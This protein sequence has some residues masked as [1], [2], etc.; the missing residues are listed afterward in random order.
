MS[1]KIFTFLPISSKNGRVPKISALTTGITAG[2]NFSKL[3]H[4][5]RKKIIYSPATMPLQKLQICFFFSSEFLLL[6]HS[7]EDYELIHIGSSLKHE[8]DAD[9]ISYLYL[10]N[11]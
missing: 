9:A 5:R 10:Y 8:Y 3:C 6:C 11:A 1:S 4:A 7:I 2:G